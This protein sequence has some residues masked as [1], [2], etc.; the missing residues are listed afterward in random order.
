MF[1]AKF[2]YVRPGSLGEAVSILSQ[3]DDAKVLA[4]GHS[5]IPLMKLRL[6]SPGTLV[7]IGRLPGLSYI[8]DKGDHV[9]IGAMT[10]HHDIETSQDLKRLVPMLPYVASLVGDPSVRHRGTIGGSIAHGDG[11]SDLP[12]AA[13]ALN[14]QMVVQGTSGER[15]IPAKEFFV[16]FLETALQPGEILTEIRVPKLSGGWSYQKFNRRAQDWA[17]VGVAVV[18]NGS[19][20]ISLVNMGSVPL[21]ASAAEQAL[22]SG[23]S[24]EDASSRASEGIDPPS[25]LN[26]SSDYRRHLA[27]VLLK[28]ALTEALG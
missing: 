13:L 22:G 28:R 16:G 9:A 24:I 18:S 5:L 26:A 27:Q 8:E 7:D 10:R 20:A 19:T 23:A 11:A 1:P 17:I 3:D 15:I 25:D 14:A 12:A 4:G 6:A 21:R 2:D